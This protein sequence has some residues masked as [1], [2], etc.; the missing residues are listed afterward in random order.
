MS[1]HVRAT[2]SVKKIVNKC[3]FNY[4]NTFVGRARHVSFP[5]VSLR[6]ACTRSARQRRVTWFFSC[7]SQTERKSLRESQL[8]PDLLGWHMIGILAAEDHRRG[9]TWSW[10]NVWKT[11][12]DIT[13]IFGYSFAPP[14]QSWRM[15][16]DE[17]SFWRSVLSLFSLF[18]SPLCVHR[19]CP[20]LRT[21]TNK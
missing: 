14:G 1:D 13:A 6:S 19:R 3:E 10:V 16:R 8:R 18:L 11:G 21:T 20:A 4:W 17:V 12:S 7:D 5:V 9:G 15:E 2:G